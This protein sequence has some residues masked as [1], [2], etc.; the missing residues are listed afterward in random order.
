VI[1]TDSG[2][3]TVMVGKGLLISPKFNALAVP[4]SIT[5]REKIIMNL[6]ILPLFFNW[7]V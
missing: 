7:G 4:A 2:Y 1:V 6:F 5:I 3:T